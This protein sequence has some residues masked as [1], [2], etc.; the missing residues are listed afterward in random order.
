MQVKILADSACDLPLDFYKEYNV[1]LFPLKVQLN[2][3]EYEDVKTI[4]P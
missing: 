2:G 1:T 3:I 4:E